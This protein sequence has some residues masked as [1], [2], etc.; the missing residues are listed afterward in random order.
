MLA[1]DEIAKLKWKNGSEEL[2]L[3]D[4]INKNQN[5]QNL[6]CYVGTDSQPGREYTKF[7]TSVCLQS[8]KGIRFII[9][10]FRFKNYPLFTI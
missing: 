6:K 2:Q 9:H 10:T 5:S 8:N 4:F 7:A 1:D 3:I